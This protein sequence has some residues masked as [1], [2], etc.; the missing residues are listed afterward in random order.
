VIYKDMNHIGFIAI[1]CSA[2]PN[3]AKHQNIDAATIRQWHR[4]KGWRDI[5]YHY[6]IKRDGTVEKGRADNIPGAHEPRINANSLAICL[7]GGAPPLG[8]PAE[9]AGL[10]ENNYTDAQWHSLLTLVTDL[11]SKHPN[12]VV[13]GH[14]D[15]PGVRKAC[16]SFDAIPWWEAH[17]PK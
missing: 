15:V 9:K 17:R 13:L 16:P 8:S 3:D 2:T 10:G 4:A 14:R 7:V 6:V 11:H 1:H 12:A 5:G